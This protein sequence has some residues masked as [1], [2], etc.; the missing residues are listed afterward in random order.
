MSETALCRPRLAPYCQGIG[1]DVG[2]GGDPITPTSINVDLPEPY[3]RVGDAPTHLYHVELWNMVAYG[4]DAWDYIFSSHLLEDFSY[5]RNR[6]IIHEWRRL[7]KPGGLLVLYG[8]DQGRYAA[9]CEA[10]GQPQNPHHFEPDF[11]LA[12]FWL[13][14]LN[15]TGPWEIVHKNPAVDTYSWELVARKPQVNP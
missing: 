5:P 12:T 6:Q 15:P 10:T 14:V 3:A 8:P 1:L 13:A 2:F 11:G 7:L 4:S 9:H